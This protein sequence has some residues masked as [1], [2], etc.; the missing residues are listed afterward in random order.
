LAPGC[1]E[2]LLWVVIGSIAGVIEPILGGMLVGVIGAKAIFLVIAAF[3]II[4][5][6]SSLI[7]RIPSQGIDSSKSLYLEV[8][9]RDFFAAAKYLV[10]NKVFCFQLLLNFFLAQE[11]LPSSG[12][13]H[14]ISESSM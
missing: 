10:A 2:L 1:P 7:P 6:L 11:G 4:S 12:K 3:L 8:I 9:K 5:A 14:V 13:F